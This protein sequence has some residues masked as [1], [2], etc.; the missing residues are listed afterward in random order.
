M[1]KAIVSVSV[2]LIMA[3][4]LSTGCQKAA[5][6]QSDKKSET[7]KKAESAVQGSAS[8]EAASQETEA[9]TIRFAVV[10]PMTGDAASQGAQQLNGIQLAV[11]EINEAGGILGKNLEFDVYDDQLNPNQTIICAEKIVADPGYRFVMTTV[12]SGGT[13]ASYPVYKTVDLPVIAGINTADHLT[14]HGFENLLRVSYRDNANVAQLCDLIV[15]E[16][17]FQKPAIIYTVSDTD[18]SSYEYCTGYL[19]DTYGMEF[20]ST[21]CVN[22]TTEKDYTAHVTNFKN[23]GADCVI[24][25]SEYSPAAL[26]TKQARSLGYDGQIFSLGGASNPQFIEIAGEA[27]EG[28]VSVCG[29]DPTVEN[30]QVQRF[31]EA[32]KELSGFA[33]GE[34]GAGCYDSIYVVAEAL[35]SKEAKDL[36][37]RDLVEWLRANTDYSGVTG[38]V[39]FDGNGDNVKCKAHFIQVKDGAFQH[40]EP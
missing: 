38:E 6:V 5:S 8:Q 30:E 12:S 40:F 37:G 16:M 15:N 18:V 34:W 24:I 13:Q 32:Y 36:T 26:F 11:N 28:F 3:M 25:M 33:P 17:K 35:K 21:A 31:V 29:F 39:A 10:G 27:A 20:I 23:Q 14:Q 9:G 4:V 7:T 1:K 19:E 22:P 2:C